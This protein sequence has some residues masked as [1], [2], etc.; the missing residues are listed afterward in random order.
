[1]KKLSIRIISLMLVFVFVLGGC[2]NNDP[3][4]EKGNSQRKDQVHNYTVTETEDYIVKNGKSDYVVVFPSEGV[5]RFTSAAVSE[6]LTF[7]EKATGILLKSS[8]D[9]GLTFDADKKY[10]SIGDT[11]LSKEAG[12]E[13]DVFELGTS[14]FEIETFGKSIF[15]VG[16]AY[17]EING[18]YGLLQVYFDFKP[19]AEDEVYVK[20]GV[21]DQ[22]FLNITAK[23]IPDIEHVLNPYA[24][25]GMSDNR[26]HLKTVGDV[27]AGNR[28]YVWHNILDGII[29]FELYGIDET[30]NTD[31]NNNIITQK[32]K[33]DVIAY[34]ETVAEDMGI[35]LTEVQKY[36]NHPEW[37]VM[38]EDRAQDPLGDRNLVE[39]LQVNLTIAKDS[40]WPHEKASSVTDDDV[41]T[42]Q[43]L[44]YEAMLYE[45]KK[46]LKKT[47][48]REMA[49]TAE[50]N[51]YWSKD[52][53]SRANLDKY[54]TDAAEY[55]HC[56]NY[57]AS[58]IQKE[59][60]TFRMTLFAYSGLKVAPTKLVDGKYVAI[61]DT[62]LLNDNVDIMMCFSK[63]N[64]TVDV[65]DPVENEANA[66]FLAS[67]E[68]LLKRRTAWMYGLT[69]YQDYFVPT[70]TLMGL[71]NNYRYLFEHDYK[72]VFDEAQVGKHVS[73]DWATLKTYIV[74]Q[75]G[76]NVY[77]DIN[78]LIEEFFTNY[79]KV[80]AKPMLEA[81]NLEQDRL[82]Q[83]SVD[84]ALPPPP[85]K[86][87]I[88]QW[89]S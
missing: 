70:S 55:I 33:D 24:D 42:S 63:H 73:P 44:L 31:Y 9:V 78:G 59:Y 48:T 20:S 17:G 81:F 6:L 66:T 5:K 71:G 10:I 8:S 52:E 54:G 72:L 61:D 38:E 14:G 34:K 65:L 47:N 25:K 1:M 45:M 88:K 4:K 77:Q 26:M 49:F 15:I 50:D 28:G 84:M 3:E 21:V 2:K 64:R 87:P 80:A 11:T 58:E 35:T 36:F 85:K 83:L 60:P 40:S 57:L 53:I 39:P 67:W 89:S 19:Y 27:Y 68:P 51:H 82:T 16:D 12:I 29:P 43:N 32:M 76:W 86:F 37:Y 46:V 79:F 69:Y 18:V 7:F 23:D 56:A 30:A 41:K 75:I 13:Y 74:S 62:V 22:K